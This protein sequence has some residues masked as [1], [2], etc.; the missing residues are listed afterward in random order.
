MLALLAPAVLGGR[1]LLRRI[2]GGPAALGGAVLTVLGLAVATRS[3]AATYRDA[4]S[5]WQRAYDQRD[6]AARN[7]FT[8]RLVG[9]YAAGRF[10]AGDE[11]TAHRLFDEVLTLPSPT[12]AERLQ[13]ATSLHRRGRHQEALAII[14]QLIAETPGLARAH[15]MRGTFL[16]REA[17]RVRAAPDAPQWEQAARSS[18]RATELA[19]TQAVW[20]VELARIRDAQG[21][22]D[23]AE[24]AVATAAAMPDCPTGVLTL[25]DALL[26]RLSRSRDAEALWQTALARRSGDVEVWIAAAQAAISAKDPALAR[27]RLLAARRLAPGRADID[28]ALARLPASTPR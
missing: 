11:A 18:T 23:A 9:S 8:T 17:E 26:R 1:L 16:A 6:P 2:G 7:T 13:C 25:H 5:F 15:G 10:A 14:D 22:L 19:P 27:E 21:R 12:A 28:S 20:W 3:H 24:R 4:T